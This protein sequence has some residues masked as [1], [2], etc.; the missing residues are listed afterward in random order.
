[1]ELNDKLKVLVAVNES[2]KVIYDVMD[3]FQK[4]IEAKDK[5]IKD[6]DNE[7]RN[8]REIIRELN[9]KLSYYSH[10]NQNQ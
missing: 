3:K 10:I 6:L 9:E 7:V 1:M 5:Q 2:N 4:E 8:L